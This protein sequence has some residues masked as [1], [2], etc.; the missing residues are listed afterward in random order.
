M[1]SPKDA[2]TRHLR[3]FRR[4][5]LRKARRAARR[6][7]KA[8]RRGDKREARN[9]LRVR[10]RWRK[11][12]Q[13]YL[14]DIRARRRSLKR[15]L[16]LPAKSG[17]VWM[18]GKEVAA[19]IAPILKDARASGVWKGGVTSGFRSYAKQFWIY[20]VARIRPAAR[21]GT[22]N[23]EGS[24]YPR[25]AVDVSDP[26]GLNRYLDSRG[27]TKLRWYRDTVGPGDDWHFSGSGR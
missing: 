13:G 6:R 23:H 21:P 18:D 19:W 20:Y 16:H 4:Q 26:W 15:R 22:S 3:T 1:A 17:T 14:Q 11:K 10:R 25:G 12:A 8:L 24:A 2:R 27:I 5:A 7:R 9:A